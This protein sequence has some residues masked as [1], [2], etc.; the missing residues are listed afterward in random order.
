MSVDDIILSVPSKIKHAAIHNQAI[1]NSINP[2]TFTERLSGNDIKHL[3]SIFEIYISDPK[4]YAA[5]EKISAIAFS[6]ENFRKELTKILD[7]RE[8][9]II[10]DL[11]SAINVGNLVLGK[12]I[13][14]DH[15]N[16]SEFLSAIARNELLKKPD[17]IDQ[18]KLLKLLGCRSFIDI[19]NNNNTQKNEK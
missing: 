11:K 5:L 18:D 14:L 4:K 8:E 1:F 2:D 15:S 9:R 12:I 7:A 19:N 16:F 17:V 6:Y 10:L 13:E 3:L